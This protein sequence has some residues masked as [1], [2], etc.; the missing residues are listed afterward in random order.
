M[1][2]LL[3]KQVLEEVHEFEAACLL[4]A[5]QHFL[6]D[7]LPMDISKMSDKIPTD[8]SLPTISVWK[9]LMNYCKVVFRVHLHGNHQ[10]MDIGAGNTVQKRYRMVQRQ[11]RTGE[12]EKCQCG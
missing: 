7:S 12:C 5:F 1:G 4:L 10:S 3:G 9:L 6:S 11:M 2:C 8:F